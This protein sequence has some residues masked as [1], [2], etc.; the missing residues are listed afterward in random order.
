MVAF[1]QK[2]KELNVDGD[3]FNFG[4]QQY[5]N[6]LFDEA[7][8]HMEYE[9]AECAKDAYDIN[10]QTKGDMRLLCSMPVRLAA[11][12]DAQYGEDWRTDR[13]FIKCYQ[14]Y[15]G[16]TFLPEPSMNYGN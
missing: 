1:I 15:M 16:Q 11:W 8:K 5:W 6:N 3:E 7:K 2:E 13:D 14:R 4:I 12:L 9:L 10:A